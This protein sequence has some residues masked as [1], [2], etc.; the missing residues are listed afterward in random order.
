LLQVN[1]DQSDSKPFVSGLSTTERERKRKREGEQE[2]GES[3][4]K[5]REKE[6]DKH[7]SQ[8]QRASVKS[9]R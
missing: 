8:G 5:E 1:F 9:Q 4:E 3:R 7:N 2:G 6:G